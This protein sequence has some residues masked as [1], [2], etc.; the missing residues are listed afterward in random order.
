M[1]WRTAAASVLDP[2]KGC[3]VVVHDREQTS[4]ISSL[5]AWALFREVHD[6]YLSWSAAGR[7]RLLGSR[8]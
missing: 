7:H 5:L 6:I 1:K 8:S 2:C 3:L 4:T